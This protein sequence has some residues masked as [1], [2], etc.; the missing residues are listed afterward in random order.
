MTAM[1]SYLLT[2]LDILQMG[3]GTLVPIGF[4]HVDK[5]C[6]PR[7]YEDVYGYFLKLRVFFLS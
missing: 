4:G 2:L 1:F 3:M 6:H 7:R 5:E